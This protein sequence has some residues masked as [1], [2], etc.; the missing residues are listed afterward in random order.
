MVGYMASVDY[1]RPRSCWRIRYTI[2]GKRKPIYAPSRE[3]A[4]AIQGTLDRP[5]NRYQ[6]AD[7]Q[8]PRY[9]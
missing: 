8:C 1:H 6:N 5:G 9:R 4:I 2:F 7:R 3:S